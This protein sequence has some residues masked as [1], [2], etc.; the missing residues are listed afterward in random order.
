M[1]FVGSLRP[2]GDAFRA[3]FRPP[4]QAFRGG[5][6]VS[7]RVRSG[8]PPGRTEGRLKL[9][10]TVLY[11][12]RL[13]RFGV[14]V[15]KKMPPKYSRGPSSR[16]A[17]GHRSRCPQVLYR[18]KN[19][20][21]LGT[22]S[23]CACGTAGRAQ[24]EG[25]FDIGTSAHPQQVKKLF[26]CFI[27]GR[28]FRLCHVRFG[29]RSSR[30]RR[31]GAWPRRRRATRSSAATTPSGRRRKTRS[32]A[33]HGQRAVYDIATFAV[34]DYFEGRR[35]SVAADPQ[36]RRPSVRF[37]RT[38]CACCARSRWRRASASRSSAT[39]GRRSAAARRHREEH[40]ARLLDEI[41]KIL[42][43]GRRARRSNAAPGRSG[44]RTCCRRRRTRSPK[45]R[46]ASGAAGQPGPAGRLPE[47]RPRGDPTT[48]RP[49]LLMGTLLVPLGCPSAGAVAAAPRPDP[50]DPREDPLDVVGEDGAL[51]GDFEEPAPPPTAAPV[52]VPL[53]FARRDA[54]RAALSWRRQRAARGEVHTSPRASTCWRAAATSRMALRWLEIH[55]GVAGAELAADWRALQLDETMGP[56]PER[57]SRPKAPHRRGAPAASPTPPPRSRPRQAARLSSAGVLIAGLRR[58]I[59]DRE[60]H[61]ALLDDDEIVT[62]LA[63]L[64]GWTREA[65]AIRQRERVQGFAD[66]LGFA[67]RVAVIAASATTTRTPPAVLNVTL[68][69]AC[70][71]RRPD[72]ARLRPGEGR[73]RGTAPSSA[74]RPAR[75]G[76]VRVLGPRVVWS[77][78]REALDVRER[79]RCRRSCRPSAPTSSSTRRVQTR[80]TSRS[81][82]RPRRSR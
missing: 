78:G 1:L 77:G 33:L 18:L 80:S 11:N 6:A 35:T 70:Q 10:R 15:T 79:R 31:S 21:Y 17:Q 82:S 40:P 20:G 75:T 46:A 7:A 42:R 29:A 13:L 26:A 2:D 61:M 38:Q 81:P 25:L 58:G 67:S 5:G 53:P 74:P 72:R 22:W 62:R 76:V 16:L 48:S 8:W 65:N 19:H 69:R 9:C 41:Y 54:D 55:V 32:A 45:S 36:H 64:P 3:R 57:R 24:A 63:A 66:A 39:R 37:R 34:I 23:G 14:P 60:A 56:A 28:R 52:L 50:G 71:T 49:P 30:S 43:Q 44:S 59:V 47:R 4:A 27:V 51:G 68:P 73:R 12:P